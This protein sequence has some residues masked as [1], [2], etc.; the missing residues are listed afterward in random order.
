[1]QQSCVAGSHEVVPHWI[2]TTEEPS[3]V[4][5]EPSALRASSSMLEPPSLSM[6]APA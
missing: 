4:D 5:L 2:G 3:R 1:M 6:N